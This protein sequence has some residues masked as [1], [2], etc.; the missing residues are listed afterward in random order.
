MRNGYSC[1]PVALSEGLDIRLNQ[2]VRQVNYSG[3]KIEITTYSPRNPNQTST[4]TGNIPFKSILKELKF[5][6]LRQ[7]KILYFSFLARRCCP[8]HVT[9]GSSQTGYFE[10]NRRGQNCK[11]GRICSS[12]TGLETFSYSTTWLRQLE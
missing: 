2:A 9:S 1:L 8:V 3:E 12:S 11:C 7:Y 4:L 5:P 10:P 6:T